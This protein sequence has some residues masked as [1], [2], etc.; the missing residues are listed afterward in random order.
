MRLGLLTMAL[1]LSACAKPADKPVE[2]PA[3]KPPIATGPATPTKVEGPDLP[4]KGA[5]VAI[6]PLVL[7]FEG[8]LP[9][10]DCS[11]IRTRLVLTRRAAGWAEGTYRLT[12]TYIGRGGPLVTRGDWTTLRGSAADDD[13]TIYELNPDDADRARHFLR[14]GEDKA[15]RTLDRDLK[16]TFRPERLER[17]K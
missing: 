1:L 14:L 4:A 10:A 8:V 17:V 6:E 2:K 3:P 13:D 12:E 16:P 7:T 9:C 5:D 15:L 11:G